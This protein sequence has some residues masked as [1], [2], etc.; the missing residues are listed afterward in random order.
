MA[1]KRITKCIH[2]VRSIKDKNNNNQN[3]Y[4]L[5]LSGGMASFYCFTIVYTITDAEN[6]KKVMN[7]KSMH[8]RKIDLNLLRNALPY[9]EVQKYIES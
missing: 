6:F 9:I 3:E 7:L 8:P 1:L 5:T 2:K 4:T